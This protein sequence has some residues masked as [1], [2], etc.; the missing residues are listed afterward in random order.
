MFV[1]FLFATKFLTYSL[2]LIFLQI[3]AFL[4]KFLSNCSIGH[5]F[6]WAVAWDTKQ[7]THRKLHG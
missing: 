3:R 7:I 5:K 2:K 4:S 1:A 6:T